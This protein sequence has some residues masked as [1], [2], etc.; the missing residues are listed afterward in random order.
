MIHTCI[1]VAAVSGLA[2]AY[3]FY[4]N[5]NRRVERFYYKHNKLLYALL[6]FACFL[7][8]AGFVLNSRHLSSEFLKMFMMNFKVFRDISRWKDSVIARAA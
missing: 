7:L 8:A 1:F 2:L 6:M 5:K 4:Y 3:F